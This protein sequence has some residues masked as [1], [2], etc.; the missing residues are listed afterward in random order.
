MRPACLTATAAK[1]ARPCPAPRLRHEARGVATHGAVA[2]PILR[3]GAASVAAL[4]LTMP[5]L[6]FLDETIRALCP[7]I[8]RGR[9]GRVAAI[10]PRS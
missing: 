7:S 9:A 8:D 4:S 3:G 10:A 5:A 2:V 6:R 1:G